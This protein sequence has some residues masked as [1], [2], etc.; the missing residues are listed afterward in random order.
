MKYVGER[1]LQ[2]SNEE[3]TVVD[4]LTAAADVDRDM[5]GRGLSLTQFYKQVVAA[6][7]G[8]EEKGIKGKKGKQQKADA[9]TE[10]EEEEAE[11]GEQVAA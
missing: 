8:E 3:G 5:K 1:Q 11:G 7:G 9:D 6:Q 10:T 2:L 4:V